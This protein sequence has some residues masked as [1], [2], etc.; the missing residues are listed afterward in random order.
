M[1]ESQALEAEKKTKTTVTLHG[2]PFYRETLELKAGDDQ[3]LKDLLG[4]PG[5]FTAYVGEKKCGGFHPD[6]AVEWAVGGQIYQSLIC[7]GCGEVQV[8]GPKGDAIYDTR[9]DERKQ[10]KA[11]LE[12]Y[13][14][15]RPPFK[16]TF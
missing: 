11:L 3:K 12:P 13:R 10:L 9:D 14:K 7:F 16:Q 5:S 6:Y 1:Y 15:N 8:Y 4:N 2:F